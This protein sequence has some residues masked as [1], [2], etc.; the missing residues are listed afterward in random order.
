M[1]NAT[2]NTGSMGIISAL[3]SLAL[4]IIA[5]LAWSQ[6]KQISSSIER[7]WSDPLAKES[8]LR[9]A[10]SARNLTFLLWLVPLLLALVSII[11]YL[12]TGSKKKAE[13]V[14]HLY[15]KKHAMGGPQTVYRCASPKFIRPY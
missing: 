3:I 14:E 2:S 13:K 8:T 1:E 11:C 4:F 7:N 10:N 9:A 5:L 6:T 15:K 12:S